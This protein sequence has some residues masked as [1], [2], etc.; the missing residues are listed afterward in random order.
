[1]RYT[2][3]DNP[4]LKCAVPQQNYIVAQVVKPMHGCTPGS[5]KQSV[6]SASLPVLMFCTGM[7]TQV[8]VTGAGGRTGGLIVKNLLKHPDQFSSVVGTVRPKGS[9]QKLVADGLPE[10][11]LV[12]LDLAAAVA[13][14]GAGSDSNP[15]LEAFKE[16]LAGADTLVI[17]TSGVP[18]IKYSSLIGVIAGR[19]VGRKS[20]PGFT[21]K[22]GQLPEQVGPATGVACCLCRLEL[23]QE[24]T[25]LVVIHGHA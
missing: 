4:W 13:A 6:A 19:L 23:V 5:S 3:Q 21:W 8:V 24:H 11:N 9:G 10:S 18:Q 12:E 16:A 25:S 20:M 1:M 15:A 17:A 2:E 22:Q 7:Q 14:A